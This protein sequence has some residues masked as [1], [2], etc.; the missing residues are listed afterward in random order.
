M[1]EARGRNGVV[2]DLMG[3]SA[4]IFNGTDSMRTGSMSQHHL[5]VCISNAVQVGNE[6]RG[7][8]LRIRATENLHLL[9]NIDKSTEGLNTSFFQSHVCGIRH[10]SG[11]HHSS[12]N[13]KCF[14][15]FLGLRIDHLDCHRLFSRNSWCDFRGKNA[16]SIINRP[17]TNQQSFSLLGDFSIESRHELVHCLDESH[18]GSKRGIDVTELKT[19]VTRTNDCYPFWD[20]A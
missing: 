8:I 15:M 19:N 4:N 16:C 11:G 1:S 17:I 2:V 5:S 9:I 18:F 20:K 6:F 7:R 3:T 14:D 10:P 12:V 13:L